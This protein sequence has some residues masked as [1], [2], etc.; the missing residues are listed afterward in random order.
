MGRN[1]VVGKGSGDGEEELVL[2]GDG[3]AACEGAV[4]DEGDRSD[5]LADGVA[6]GGDEGEAASL[7]GCEDDLGAALKGGDDGEGLASGGEGGAAEVEL[8]EQLGAV[9]DPELDE[10]DVGASG[11]FVFA[12]GGGELEGFVASVGDED[13]GE[14][15]EGVDGDAGDA[16]GD[17]TDGLFDG[18]WGGG[19]LD[20]PALG[21]L[22]EE[23]GVDGG[24]G[25]CWCG[26]GASDVGFGGWRGGGAGGGGG[27]RGWGGAR[28]GRGCY[29]FD[30]ALVGGVGL[31]WC[32]LNDDGEEERA[33]D[34]GGGKEVGGA[35]EAPEVGIRFAGRGW[36]LGA[37]HMARV[38]NDV[39]GWRCGFSRSWGGRCLDGLGGR[40]VRRPGAGR[41]ADA[42]RADGG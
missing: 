11:G 13:A 15:V 12:E 40:F 36:G 23:R 3:C 35:E 33:D 29:G 27:G 7:A 10:G 37:V 26:A 41:S 24:C 22:L 20:G 6:N 18:E 32:G 9:G 1:G 5:G 31:P 38:E 4:D 2:A 14:V 39:A 34:D 17:A 28:G 19:L 21:G 8:A 30:A 25:G 16:D 42:G